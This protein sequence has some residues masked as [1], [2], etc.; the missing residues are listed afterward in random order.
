MYKSLASVYDDEFS[1]VMKEMKA[2]KRKKKKKARS[3]S[4]K[5][6]LKATKQPKLRRLST[7]AMELGGKAYGEYARRKR[8]LAADMARDLEKEL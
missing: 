2:S 3:A 8:S 5:V 7:V 6:A 4:M 1:A